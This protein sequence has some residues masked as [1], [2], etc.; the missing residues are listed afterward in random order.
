MLKDRVA[1]V[2]TKSQKWVGREGGKRKKRPEHSGQ[3]GME[4]S[5]RRHVVR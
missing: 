1:G 4:K 3:T 5:D 2:D